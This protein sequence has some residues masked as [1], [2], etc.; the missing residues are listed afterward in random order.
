MSFAGAL[1]AF[2]P[3][4]RVSTRLSRKSHTIQ[5]Y[6]AK[7]N[8]VRTTRNCKTLQGGRAY[9]AGSTRAMSNEETAAKAA[10]A[11][12][13]ADAGAP[14][15]FDKIIS[16][17]IPA[18]I[19]Y[20]DDLCLAFRDIAPQAPTHVLVIPKIRAGL[21]QLSKAVPEHKDILGHLLYT[22]QAVAKSEKLDKGF[23]IVVND[24]EEGCQSV[25]HLHL[26][27]L[28]GRQLTWPPG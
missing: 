6:I 26:H 13:M 8:F 7:C 12:G 11:A 24:G 9:S 10:A 23:R 3:L 4:T 15:I 27:I 2:R 14:T 16:K 20:E 5:R 28:G 21:T 25:F 17:E 18:N 1:N 22:A 19:V